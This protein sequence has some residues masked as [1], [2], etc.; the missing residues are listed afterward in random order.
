[1]HFWFFFLSPFLSYF[2]FSSRNNEWEEK[3]GRERK[4]EKVPLLCICESLPEQE[5][6]SRSFSFSIFLSLSSSFLP[7]LFLSRFSIVEL[8]NQC[9]I[10]P[11]FFFLSLFLNFLSFSERKRERK[12]WNRF[13]PAC[14]CSSPSLHHSF[15][16][17]SLLLK[18]RT[19]K[20]EIFCTSTFSTSKNHTL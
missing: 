13:S 19:F 14:I 2:L 7:F 9:S 16:H 17:P 18:K 11:S 6:K 12:R 5:V 15:I 20:P 1:M 3:R 10:L 4:R 8:V